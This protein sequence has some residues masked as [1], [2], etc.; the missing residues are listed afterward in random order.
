MVNAEWS[1][2]GTH[3]F[4]SG[5]ML[6]G[7]FL[8][9]E[10]CS[11]RTSCARLAPCPWSPFPGRPLPLTAFPPLTSVNRKWISNL[12]RIMLRGRNSSNL[13]KHLAAS[14]FGVREK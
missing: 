12:I 2:P 7:C 14:Y 3:L 6:L 4:S 11:L 5:G 10:E 8:H 9:P 13:V 1:C